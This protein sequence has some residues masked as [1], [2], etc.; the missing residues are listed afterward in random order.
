MT[1]WYSTLLMAFLAT[2]A[3]SVLACESSLPLKGAESIKTC[4]R[5][6]PGC[7]P[8]AKLVHDYT[9]AIPEDPKLFTIALQSSP[10]RFY[11]ADMRILLPE[12]LAAMIKAHWKS[13]MEKVVLHASWTGVAP[14]RGGKSLA[15]KLS[16]ALGG[17]PVS[18][19]D[20]FLWLAKDG[21]MR[22][23]HKAFSM[24]QGSGP[25]FAMEG[26][27]VM[28]S[29]AAGWFMEVEDKILEKH[30]ADALMRAGAGWD[31]YGLCP[32]HALK[33]FEAAAK[34]SNPIAAYNA[35]LMRLQRNAEGDV[36]AAKNLLSL[37]AQAGDSKAQAK[38][39]ALSTKNTK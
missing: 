9:E 13:G 36:E 22:T 2:S 4:E 19:S 24:K 7:T 29:L 38:L 6:M 11:D 28:V 18:G 15:Q 26:D 33:T 10:W 32:D 35:A 16:D 31:I 20:G 27:E 12:E 14:E 23:T 8:A 39:G 1:N 5:Q 30:D 25:Y 21:S 37:A 17:F 34:L 3:D